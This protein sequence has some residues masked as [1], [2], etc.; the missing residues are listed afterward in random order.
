MLVR[1]LTPYRL[2]LLKIEVTD[3]RRGPRAAIFIA[4]VPSDV[5]TT[6]EPGTTG[7][8]VSRAHVEGAEPFRELIKGRILRCGP[9]FV[10]GELYFDRA[11]FSVALSEVRLGDFLEIDPFG[12][13]SKM[14]SALCEAAFFTEAQ[15]FGFGVTR[16]PENVA[17]HVGTQNYHDFRLERGQIVYRVELKSLWGTDTTKARLI[18]TVSRS[19]GG[20][21]SAR[22]D[23]QIWNTSSCRFQDQDLFAVSLWLRT[24]RITDFAY[25]LSVANDQHAEWGLPKVPR[26]PDHVTQNPPISQPPTDPWTPDL[27]EASRRVDAWRKLRDAT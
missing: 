12:V 7:K 27:L 8:V 24:G 3:G 1:V 21:N 11:R 23:R 20:K 13:T 2:K 22:D 15:R 26:H 4:E 10:E 6:F 16:M 5:W 18:H 9:G 19:G 14:E 25:A 17:K